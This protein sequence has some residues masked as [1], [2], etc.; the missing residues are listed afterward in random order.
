[1]KYIKRK[2]HRDKLKLK[3][4]KKQTQRNWKRNEDPLSEDDTGDGMAVRGC[5]GN[6]CGKGLNVAHK[7]QCTE[8]REL[9]QRKIG[10]NYT[11]KSQVKEVGF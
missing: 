2:P 6:F 10:N 11:N 5:H 8:M 1:M 3:K 4:K 7:K 9:A